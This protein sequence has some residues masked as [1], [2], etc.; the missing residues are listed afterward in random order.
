[1]A[2]IGNIAGVGIFGRGQRRNM[3]GVIKILVI[4]LLFSPGA[5]T[6]A[7]SVPTSVHNSIRRRAMGQKA[8]IGQRG[9]MRPRRKH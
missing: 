4:D 3:C 5:H 8:Q 2:R 9:Q 1:M 6:R 7:C